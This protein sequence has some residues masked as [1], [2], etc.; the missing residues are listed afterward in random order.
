MWSVN[1]CTDWGDDRER[2]AY[3]PWRFQYLVQGQL[4]LL[5]LLW[6]YVSPAWQCVYW[7]FLY[8]VLWN[9]TVDW[10]AHGYCRVHVYLDPCATGRKV[11]LV[12]SF[13]RLSRRL[14]TRS[15]HRSRWLPFPLGCSSVMWL[16]L[17]KLVLLTHPQLLCSRSKGDRI[18]VR[19]AIVVYFFVKKEP[20]HYLVWL[21]L[22]SWENIVK[23]PRACVPV[24]RVRDF[25]MCRARI[26][27]C[28]LAQ[29]LKVANS[30][31][32]I[33]T[34]GS[35]KTAA[36]VLPML[37]YISKLPPMT[38]EIEAEGTLSTL[39]LSRC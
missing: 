24:T 31:P 13:W 4:T 2:L 22:A 10:F 8:L 30:D 35:G 21:P 5:I 38:E 14:V 18:W 26:F 15:H 11:P 29:I 36:F 27:L 25:Q 23:S 16:A 28:Y 32:K 1:L 33:L 12:Q 17:R 37:T 6:H 39:L 34:A 3:F 20:W 19:D 7:M 9:L